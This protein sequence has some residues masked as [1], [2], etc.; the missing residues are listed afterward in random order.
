MS[1]TKIKLL[2]ASLHLFRAK[3]YASTTV[4]DLCKAVGLTK[5]SFFHH[6]KSKEDLA[7]AAAE[8]WS[9]V[10]SRLFAEAPYHLPEDPLE[11]VLGYIDFRGA[12][13]QGELPQFTCLLGTLVQETYDTHPAIREACDRGI[14]L[15]AAEV[16]KDIA[17]ARSKYAPESTW[18]PESLALFT[19]AALQGAFILAK[20]HHGTEVA[21]ETVAHL[22]RYV[23]LL[24]AEAK[25]PNPGGS[26]TP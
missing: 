21:R 22:R 25:H 17:L 10:T 26:K 12:I 18:S 24:F 8:Y 16:E 14:R 3:G 15:H 20:A 11:R 4:D 9:E 5:G 23:E 7:V 1:D 2:D 19:Q 13:L 6:F